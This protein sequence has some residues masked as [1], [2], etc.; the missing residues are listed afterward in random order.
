MEEELK[1]LEE[2]VSK[3]YEFGFVTNIE[4]DVI[5]KGIDED[6]I[7]LIS[8]KKNEPE[9]MLEWRLKAYHVWKSMEEPTWPNVNYPKINLNQTI[10]SA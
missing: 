7:R 8:S 3:E 4:T 6:V 5:N 9:W 10:S 1:M 2:T